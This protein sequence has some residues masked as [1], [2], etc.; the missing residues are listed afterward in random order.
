MAKVYAARHQKD[1]YTVT[2]EQKAAA[3]IRRKFGIRRTN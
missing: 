3:R 1:V 2:A